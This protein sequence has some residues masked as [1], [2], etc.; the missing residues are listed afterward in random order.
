MEHLNNDNFLRYISENP[1]VEESIRMDVHLAQCESCAE[2]MRAFFYI[3][4]NFEDLWDTWSAEEH[5]RVYLKRTL[6]KAA[7]DMGKASAISMKTLK[8]WL[9]RID[10]RIG[11]AARFLIDTAGKVSA[12]VETG[13]SPQYG[14]RMRPVAAGVGT[15]DIINIEEK[16]KAGEEKL[17]SGC[18]D[19][20]LKLLA[21]VSSMDARLLQAR[22][23]DIYSGGK[24]KA[25]LTVDSRKRKAGMLYWPE[26][27]TDMPG[28]LL[29]SAK[30]DNGP[31]LV[32]EFKKYQSD[33]HYVAEFGKLPNGE[34]N[35]FVL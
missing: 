20:A 14:F 17:R 21:E 30:D 19:E 8:E 2:K 1:D 28:I 34:Y 6:L 23:M 15:P 13:L 5:G 27:E 9:G 29:L 10:S 4:D 22:V 32:A 3:K 18:A 26:N 33:D 11:I 24:L 35:I 12:I 16:I 25:R 31:S 7:S